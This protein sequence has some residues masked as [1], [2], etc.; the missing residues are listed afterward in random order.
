MSEVEPRP[1]TITAG[2]GQVE[3]NCQR[4]RTET[5]EPSVEKSRTN[6]Q[7]MPRTKGRPATAVPKEDDVAEEDLSM[8]PP[9]T[10]SFRK[11]SSNAASKRKIAR[12]VPVTHHHSPM[13]PIFSS[14]PR[15]RAFAAPDH[16]PLPFH[17]LGA[18]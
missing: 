4:E 12:M 7:R 9:P 1:V 3:E 2:L 6:G 16:P 15:T 5:V 8:L 11:A 10:T 17:W 13:I 18:M 14:L